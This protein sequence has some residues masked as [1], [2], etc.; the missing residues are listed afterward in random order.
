MEDAL[1]TA[2]PVITALITAVFGLL[3]SL[4]A[5]FKDELKEY[6]KKKNQGEERVVAQDF[7]PARLQGG[8]ETLRHPV[9]KRPFNTKIEILKS[10]ETDDIRFIIPLHAKNWFPIVFMSGWLLAWTAGIA[11]AGFAFF[12]MIFR[13]ASAGFSGM[14]LFAI[15]FMG[16]WLI[17]ALAG[18]VAVTKQLKKSMSSLA[19]RLEA[20]LARDGDLVLK[21]RFGRISTTTVYPVVKIDGFEHYGG[22]SSNQGFGQGDGGGIYFRYGIDRIAFDGITANEAEWLAQEL[23]RALAVTREDTVSAGDGLDPLNTVS[24]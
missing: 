7:V 23:N 17:G 20:T 6:V 11:F 12:G 14:D 5:V 13:S 10:H 9:R 21:K 18:E 22:G 8:D 16:G 19:G 3:G 15:V 2:A 1:K 4:I 24:Q